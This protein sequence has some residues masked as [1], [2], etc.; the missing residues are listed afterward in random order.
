MVTF[1][2]CESGGVEDDDD[3]SQ[4]FAFFSLE[5]ISGPRKSEQRNAINRGI[6]IDGFEEKKASQTR[7]LLYQL[8]TSTQYPMTM[9]IE[10]EKKSESTFA[11]FALFLNIFFLFPGRSHKRKLSEGKEVLSKKSILSASK[12]TELPAAADHYCITVGLF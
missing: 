1:K 6:K 5:R 3:I 10:K 2:H 12:P 11:C 7:R 4:R 8:C 9:G